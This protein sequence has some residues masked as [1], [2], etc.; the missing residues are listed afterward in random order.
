MVPAVGPPLRRHG[1][2]RRRITPEYLLTTQTG[3]D[4]RLPSTII[5][6]PA[7]CPGGSIVPKAP[8][9]AESSPAPGTTRCPAA[10]APQERQRRRRRSRNARRIGARAHRRHQPPDAPNA[11][12]LR[13]V[14]GRGITTVSQ[15]YALFT[16]TASILT[17]TP[18]D[19]EQGPAQ[20]WDRG[21]HPVRRLRARRPALP[22]RRGSPRAW[23]GRGSGRS[24]VGLR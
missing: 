11:G 4:G 24:A 21:A 14:H 1:Q 10:T 7:R 16:S 23:S 17:L 5:G 19:I 18:V 6:S 9:V 13:L 15:A 12:R 20:G 3:M 8:A 22:G 2:V